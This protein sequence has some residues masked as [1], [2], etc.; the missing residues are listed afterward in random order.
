[1]SNVFYVNFKKSIYFYILKVIFFNILGYIPKKLMT[2]KS[3]LHEVFYKRAIS[4]VPIS[5]KYLNNY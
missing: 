5:L 2:I 4:K 3:F 1:M